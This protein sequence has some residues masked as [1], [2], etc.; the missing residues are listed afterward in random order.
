MAQVTKKR[1]V[2]MLKLK[3]KLINVHKKK[4]S[5]GLALRFLA[6]NSL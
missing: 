5:Q 4:I 2:M 3:M 6:K 1:V